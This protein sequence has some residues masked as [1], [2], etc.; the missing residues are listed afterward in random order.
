MSDPSK[1]SMVRRVSGM[2]FSSYV[3]T[4]VIQ[5]PSERRTLFTLPWRGRV[6]E[7][8]SVAR[9]E[10][11]WGDLLSKEEKLTPPRL[12]SLRSAVDPPPPGEGEESKSRVRAPLVRRL[13]I[14]VLDHLRPFRDIRLDDL[15]E[16]IRRVAG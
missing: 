2:T 11:G 13:D 14:G 9:C 10:P 12:P 8:S 3:H 1:A 4:Q 15:G 5:N 6:G 7:T 16:R